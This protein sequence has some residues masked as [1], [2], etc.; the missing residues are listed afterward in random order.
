MRDRSWE[1]WS[2]GVDPFEKQK[3][4]PG[5]EVRRISLEPISLVGGGLG[6]PGPATVK[7]DTT[8]FRRPHRTSDLDDFTILNTYTEHPEY[9]RNIVGLNISDA[10]LI[11]VFLPDEPTPCVRLICRK[12]AS[13]GTI[14]TNPPH[15]NK[16]QAMLIPE[17]FR[18]S[19]FSG[20]VCLPFFSEG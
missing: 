9:F 14:L 11:P 1:S 16:Y 15:N 7:H 19:P 2:L 17:E 8:R 6:G 12:N 4:E 18:V 20:V 13:P 10:C 5:A 3:R